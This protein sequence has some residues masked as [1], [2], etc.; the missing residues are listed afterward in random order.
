MS[1]CNM[2]VHSR[3]GST[4]VLMFA[5]THHLNSRDEQYTPS[6]WPF[7]PMVDTCIVLHIAALSAPWILAIYITRYITSAR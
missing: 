5:D 6:Y 4:L 1:W 7:R 3:C 2:V